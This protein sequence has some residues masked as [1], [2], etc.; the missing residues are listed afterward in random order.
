MIILMAMMPVFTMVG[1]SRA[2]ENVNHER[3]S[4]SCEDP[5][6]DV[7]AQNYLPVC[8]ALDDGTRKTYSNACS[9]CSDVNVV[10]YAPDACR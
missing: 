2:V 1:C 8:G 7:C 10:G 4:I 3:Q 5:R 6:P 9:A